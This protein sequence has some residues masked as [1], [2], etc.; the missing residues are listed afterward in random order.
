MFKMQKQF[1]YSEGRKAG[2]LQF[3]TFSYIKSH[4]SNKKVLVTPSEGIL[5]L[6]FLA[7]SY[8]LPSRGCYSVLIIPI[9]KSSLEFPGRL[10]LQALQWQIPNNIVFVQ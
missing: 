2:I 4:V 6:F 5:L 7:R 9:H 1:I 10:T 3:E 8:S